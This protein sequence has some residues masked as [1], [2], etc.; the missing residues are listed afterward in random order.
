M[1]ASTDTMPMPPRIWAMQ[2]RQK[3]RMRLESL[4]PPKISPARMNS[5]PAI[6]EKEFIPRIACC[7]AIKGDI[8]LP[9]IMASRPDS[10]M[11][12]QTGIPMIKN[13]SRV[14]TEI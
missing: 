6:S 13:R 9:S 14:R 1:L 7:T 4:A 8:S 3:S 10:P 11:A 2:A 12:K 5:G